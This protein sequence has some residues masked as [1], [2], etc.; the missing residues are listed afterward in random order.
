MKIFLNVPNLILITAIACG[1]L[2]SQTSELQAKQTPTN[3]SFSQLLLPQLFRDALVPRETEKPQETKTPANSQ[4]PTTNKVTNPKKINFIRPKLPPG[5]APGGRRTGG[6]RR[7]NCPDVNPKL[8]ALVPVSE[9]TN[10]ITNV[11]G[12]TS[13]ERPTFWFYLPYTKSSQYPTEFILQ[14]SEGETIHQKN[15][16]LP[17]QPG[18][19]NISLPNTVPAL[20]V[21]KEYRWFLKVYCHEEKE[22]PPVYVEG[23]VSRVNLNPRVNQKISTATPYQQAVIYAENGIWH[24]ALTILIELK[25]NSPKD[26][27]VH[28]NLASLLSEIGLSEMI[29]K[30]IVIVGKPGQS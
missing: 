26:E 6:G 21:G 30:P 16:P 20:T 13:V 4:K 25:Q 3:P 8:T 10:N 23:V 2:L 27:I 29:D 12:L 14:D 15:I 17:E 22:S 28:D 19:I 24:Q 7:D 9:E 5:N 1:N 11:W 18:I